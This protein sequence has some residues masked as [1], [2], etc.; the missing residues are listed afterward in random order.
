MARD[1][2]T[3]TLSRLAEAVLHAAALEPAERE[4]FLTELAIDQPLLAAEARRR[5]ELAA[6][7]PDSFLAL[8]AAERLASS[9]MPAEGSIPLPA[10]EQRY[11]LGELL[12]EG[13]MASV[14]RAFDRQLR[15]PVALKI[16]ARGDGEARRR[17]LAEAQAQARVRHEHVLEVYETGEIGGEAFIAMRWVDGPSL[18]ELDAGVPLEQK[19]RLLAQVAEGLHA[20]HREGLIHRDVKPSNLLVER[21]ADGDLK[22]WV[23]DFGIAQAGGTLGGAASPRFAGTPAYMAPE[24]LDP[25]PGDLDRRVDVWGLGVTLYQLFTGRLPF[26]AED[27]PALLAK[28]RREPPPPPRQWAPHLPAELEAIVLRCLAKEPEHRYPSAQAL[29]EDL[30]RYLD[31]EVVEAHAASLA[32]RLSRFAL[33]HRRL[34][35]VAGVAAGL[36]AAALTAAAVLGVEARLANRRAELRRGQAEE[37]IGFL[38]TD[39]R[40]RLDPLGKLEILDGVG[41]RALSYFAAV[42]EAE[43]SNEELARRSQALYQIGELRIRRGNLKAALGP[44]TESLAL[45]RALASREP[46]SPE[47]LFGLG[48]SHFW[49]GH[50]Y[51]EQGDLPA[52]RPHFEAYLDLSRRLVD[53]EPQDPG[54]QLELSYALS[55]LGSVERQEGRLEPALERFGETLAVQEKLL[56]TEPANQDWRFELAATHDLLGTTLIELSRLEAARPHLDAHLE[57][58]RRLAEEDP[59]NTRYREFLGTSHDSMATWL[60][61]LGRLDQALTHAEAALRTFTGLVSHDPENRF[62]LWQRELAR[63]KVGSLRT[64]LGSGREGE[65]L[66]GEAAAETE[67]QLAVDPTERKWR[68]LAARAQVQLG[69]GEQTEGRR[70]QALTRARRAIAWLVPLVDQAPRDADSLRWLAQALLVAGHASP[71]P[72]EATAYRLQAKSRLVSLAGDPSTLEVRASWAQT[73]LDLGELETA[74]PVVRTLLAAGYRH[75]DFLTSC[76][77]AGLEIPANPQRGGSR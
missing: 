38:L 72:E 52:A 18:S 74:R 60:E 35:I 26:E 76:R 33:R 61:A 40:D 31:G 9:E 25:E 6:Q 56:R 68:L 69:S 19:V 22:P 47:R 29:A 70:P 27:L 66:L 39:L 36:L 5:L 67:R 75:P 71:N 57:L 59:G 62:W 14:F 11:Q 7:L 8:P 16:L 65:A 46:G 44:L 64:W 49:V 73:L 53:L 34:L 21:T 63:V 37:L 55:N 48:Q 42:P 10:G 24:L 12:G 50:V 3:R 28:I 51:W 20:A 58:R 15:R 32:Y 30:R 17:F 2:A 54:Y 13:G 77:A 41:D 1:P 23:T 45:A 4:S 43:L